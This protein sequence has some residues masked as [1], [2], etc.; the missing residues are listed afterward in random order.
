MADAVVAG[1]S[2]RADRAV[3]VVPTAKKRATDDARRGEIAPSRDADVDVRA[4]DAS[5]A[6]LLL[7]PGGVLAKLPVSFLCERDAPAG[8]DEATRDAFAALARVNRLAIAVR[9]SPA[10]SPRFARAGFDSRKRRPGGERPMATHA[11]GAA[12]HGAPVLLRPTHST[13]DVV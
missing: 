11:Y 12:G 9:G 2:D 3:A 5:P 6:G 8:A 4:R 13:V 10:P 1:P 7:L